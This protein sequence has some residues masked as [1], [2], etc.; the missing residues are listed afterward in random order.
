M[1]DPWLDTHTA[2]HILNSSLVDKLYIVYFSSFL[3]K[4]NEECTKYSSKYIQEFL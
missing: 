3:I 1:Y 4:S 2:S